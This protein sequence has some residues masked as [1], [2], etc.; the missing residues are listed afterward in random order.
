MSLSIKRNAKRLVLN[1]DAVTGKRQNVR[2]SRILLISLL[3]LFFAVLF[4]LYGPYSG[5]R[6]FWIT[7]AMHTS[8]H[9]YLAS[10]IYPQKTIKQV[11]QANSVEILD[12][13]T[14]TDFLDVQYND[15]IELLDVSGAMCKGHLLIIHDPSRVSL[16]T[17]SGENGFLLEELC[18]PIDAVAGISASAYITNNRR[19]IPL[20]LVIS[21]GSMISPG[22]SGIHSIIGIDRSDRLILGMYTDRDTDDLNLRDAV[23]YGPFLIINGEMADISGNGGG[24]AP[25]AAIGQT[26]DGAILFL[27]LDGRELESLGATMTDVQSILAENGAINAACLDGGATVSLYYQDTIINSITGGT[28]NR[29]LPNAFVV[30]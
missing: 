19:G 16:V 4:L 17:S 29:R 5:F 10:L 26:A 7:T 18:Q 21:E 30:K 25:R 22:V 23:E 24:I 2:I 12:D 14:N 6:T 3:L 1:E 28:Y 20:G 13:K 11:L 15:S 27:V 9:K 8:D